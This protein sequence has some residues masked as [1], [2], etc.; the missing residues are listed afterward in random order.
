MMHSEWHLLAVVAVELL[1]DI[2]KNLL[3]HMQELEVI[4]MPYDGALLA[5]DDFVHHTSVIGVHSEAKFFC[6]E[7]SEFLPEQ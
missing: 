7:F 6:Q 5:V 4:N 2:L 1:R 3:F